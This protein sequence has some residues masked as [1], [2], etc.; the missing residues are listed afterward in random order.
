[1]IHFD[2][3]PIR[4]ED[5]ATAW[6]RLG[7]SRLSLEI[8]ELPDRRL[9]RAAAQVVAEELADGDTEVSVLVPRIH[10]SR[11]WHRL[12]HDRTA[13][14]IAQAM[15]DL[16]HCNVTI[17]PYHLRAGGAKRAATIEVATVEKG[18]GAYGSTNHA[19][20]NGDVRVAPPAGGVALGDAP[21]RTK[22]LIAGRVRA[23]RVQPWGGAPSLEAT[24]TDGTGEV[25]LV[26]LGR[27][28]V[29][30][31]RTGVM[32][33]AE[34]IIAPDRRGPIMLNPIYTLLA[35]GPAH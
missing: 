34:G 27:R 14:S 7:L 30:G 12:L 31:I 3:D 2:L 35:N 18:S 32:L 4:T 29:G 33:T 10:H 28:D 17:V 11:L 9:N 8:I 19:H 26:F 25:T 20:P 16:P 24:V 22:V 15:A 6:G 23:V 21:T 5:L 1:V 13:D